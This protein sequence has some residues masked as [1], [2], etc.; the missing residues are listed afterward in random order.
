MN[1]VRRMMKETGGLERA[2]RA[3]EIAT[4]LQQMK[5]LASEHK[6]PWLESAENCTRIPILQGRFA[7]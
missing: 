4:Q 6:R 7:A 2:S 3:I 1:G 5:Q